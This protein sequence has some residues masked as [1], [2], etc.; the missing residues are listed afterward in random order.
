L[1]FFVAGVTLFWSLFILPKMEKI[2]FDFKEPLP[3]ITGAV[4]RLGRFLGEFSWVVALMLLAV[5]AAAVVLLNTLAPLWYVP[6]V[7]RVYRLSVQ[8]R[9]LRMLGVLLEAGRPVPEAL[10]ILADSGAFPPR[11]RV[12]LDRTSREV[13]HGEPLADSLRRNGLLRAGLVPVVRSAQRAN[14]LPAALAQAGES[15]AARLARVLRRVSLA[16]MPVCLLAVGALVAFIGLGIFYPL[17]D[18]I[19]R[20]SE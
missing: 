3:W 15:L 16:V 20:L 17:I 13:E 5:P 10:G 18:L 4:G 14:N 19:T 9:V 6:G 7:G 12:L 8:S 11:A 2:F 1:L